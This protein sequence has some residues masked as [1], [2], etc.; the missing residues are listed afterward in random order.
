MDPDFG[1]ASMSPLFGSKK[2]GFNETWQAAGDHLI[3]LPDMQTSNGTRMLVEQL[4]LWS[5][6][7]KTRHR[8]QDTVMALWF[9]ELDA[10]R[11]LQN[12]APDRSY[13][14]SSSF[15]SQR[16]MDSRAVVNLDDYFASN[17]VVYL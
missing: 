17:P 14:G 8:K 15:H 11:I 3:H 2:R 1:V 12:T 5:P 9:A 13:F 7:V 6:L 16:D 4:C 10:R